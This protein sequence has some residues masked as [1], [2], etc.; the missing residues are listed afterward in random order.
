M[1]C[2]IHNCGFR[3]QDHDQDQQLWRKIPKANDV[4]KKKRK[5]RKQAKSR[6]MNRCTEIMNNL[7]ADTAKNILSCVEL[8]QEIPIKISKEK[9]MQVSQLYSLKPKFHLK[10][11]TFLREKGIFCGEALGQVNCTLHRLKA[12]TETE[13]ESEEEQSGEER[14]EID[15]S[16]D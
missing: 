1:T 12:T 4:K 5:I 11:L 8:S 9:D 15:K 6:L 14:E 3:G 2:D 13:L 10:A 7:G 16:A